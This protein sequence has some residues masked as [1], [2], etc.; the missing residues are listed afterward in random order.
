[1]S[2]K[3]DAFLALPLAMGLSM[4]TGA[5]DQP[6]D[7]SQTTSSFRRRGGLGTGT[8]LTY[9]TNQWVSASARDV[10]EYSPQGTWHTN[11]F[12][13]QT[14]VDTLTI[15]DPAHYGLVETNVANPA[16]NEP[17]ATFSLVADELEVVVTGPHPE[18]PE[19]AYRGDALIGVQLRLEVISAP[20]VPPHPVVLEIV[21]YAE[22][23]ISGALYEIHK[24]D[25]V[26]GAMIAPIC[27]EDANL[28]RYAR[29]YDGLRVKA[30][31]GKIEY[32]SDGALHHIACTASA[33]GKASLY[34]YDPEHVDLDTFVLANRVIRADY[35]ADGHPYTYPGNS[36]E[37]YDNFTPGSEMTFQ[38]VI[39]LP[40]STL[41]AVW[42]PNGVICVDTPRT[43]NLSR[44]EVVC[45][46]KRLGNEP[47]V[48]NWQ[49]PSCD[50]YVDPGPNK[51]RFYSKTVILPEEELPPPPPPPA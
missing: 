34:G 47:P 19:V 32:L 10:F 13:Y 8:V 41:E 45:P 35:C 23:P 7:S 21:G 49:P 42:G 4:V 27:E 30:D 9:N 2:G 12:G 37:M 16:T 44:E 17:V 5:C 26:T 3:Y 31:V 40:G 29:I 6:S 1:M 14:R 15:D 33:P 24:V 25:P 51:I 46:A 22:D 18:D 43:D 11:S 38:E 50:G 20:S 39:S 36:L 48:H 28:E